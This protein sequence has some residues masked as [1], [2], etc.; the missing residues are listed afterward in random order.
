MPLDGSLTFEEMQARISGAAPEEPDTLTFEEMQARIGAALPP[1]STMEA[2]G[3]NVVEFGKGLVPGA[4]KAAGTTLSG[5]AA[6]GSSRV[7]NEYFDRI[8]RGESVDDLFTSSADPFA[9][10]T[11]GIDHLRAAVGAY[12]RADPA[13]R[14]ELRGAYPKP[15]PVQ[16][17]ATY[18]TGQD[19]QKIGEGLLPAAPGY[20][21][22][23]GRQLGEGVG[24]VI[25]G[26]ATSALTGPL[27][28][29]AAFA[30]MGAGEAVDRAIKNGATEDQIIKSARLGLLPGVTDSIPIETLLGRLPVPG[31]KFITL[32]LNMIGSAIKVAGRIGWQATI[33]GIQEGGQAFLQNLI[34]RE[35][36]KPEQRLAENV[37]PEAGL[38]AGV[39]AI[40]EAGRQLLVGA[41]GRRGRGPAP[42]APTLTPDDRASPLPDDLIEEGKKIIAAATGGGPTEPPGGGAGAVPAPAPP[43]PGTAPTPAPPIPGAA[44]APT[45]PVTPTVEI[46]DGTQGGQEVRGPVEV[47]QE[48]G[49]AVV[50]VGGEQAA[51]AG[52]NVPPN[53]I[54]RNGAAEVAPVV[55]TTGGQAPTAPEVDQVAAEAEPAPLS[56]AQ[57]QLK[58]RVL[59]K[60]A[61]EPAQAMPAPSPPEPA[62]PTGPKPRLRGYKAPLPKRPLNIF[63]FIAQKGGIRDVGGEVRSMDLHRKFIPRFGTLVRPRGLDPDL[64]REAAEDAGYI[65]RGGGEDYQATDM[66]DLWDAMRRQNFGEEVYPAGSEG[67]LEEIENKRF[68]KM[69]KEMR[70]EVEAEA[71][72]EKL[73]LPRGPTTD[74]TDQGP[75]A[76]IPG[77]ERVSEAEAKRAADRAEM[78]RR[79]EAREA[80][81]KLRAK[82]PQAGAGALFGEPEKPKGP[83]Q[84]GLFSLPQTETPEF[85]AWFG[86]SKVVDAEGKPL[87]VFHA[88]T[89]EEQEEIAPEIGSEGFHFGT[90]TASDFR[91]GGKAID[92]FIRNI[93]TSQDDDG[94][95]HWSSEGIDSFDMDETGFDT[96][97]DAREDGE[98][99]AISQESDFSEPMPV[100]EVYLSIKNPKRVRDQKDNWTT[101]V[102]KAKEEGYDG[103]VYRN[104]FEDKGSDSWVV[105]RPEQIKSATGNRGTFD[106]NDP[107]ISYSLSPA[108]REAMPAIMEDLRARLAK[109]GIADKVALKW[110]NAIHSM[111]T[112]GPMSAEGRYSRIYASRELAKAQ[113]RKPGDALPFYR[114]IEV[115]LHAPD[116]AWTLDH[117]IIHALRD[118]VLIRPAEWTAL[119]RA[120]TADKAR[121]A[122]IRRRYKDQ[123]LEMAPAEREDALVEEAVADMFADWA[124]G[125]TEA[126]GFIRT[127]FERIKAFFTALA[128][129][130]G[131]HGFTTVDQ[132]FGRIEAGE[133]GAREA[134]GATTAAERFAAAWHGSP[135]DFDAFSTDKIGTGEGA[136][137]YG[138][139]L[140]FSGRRDVAEYYR[141]ALA[142]NRVVKYLGK[143]VASPDA[144]STVTDR[145]LFNVSYKISEG[146]APQDAIDAAILQYKGAAPTDEE[147]R[148]SSAQRGAADRYEELASAARSLKPADFTIDRGRLYRVDLAPAEDEY[149]LWDKPLSEQSEKVKAGLRKAGLVQET[150]ITDD[151]IAQAPT[152]EGDFLRAQ[153]DSLK[154][155]WLM[156]AENFYNSLA[157]AM[158]PDGALRA[159][160]RAAS[161]ALRDAGI[162]GIKYLDQGSRVPSFRFDASGTTLYGGKAT[163]LTDL[164][165]ADAARNLLGDEF[166][167]AASLTALLIRDG[168]ENVEAAK[169]AASRH[170]LSREQ[171]E[172]LAVFAARITDDA[173]HNYV[174]FDESAVKIEEKFALPRPPRPSDALASPTFANAKIEAEWRDARKGAASQE[175]M[176]TRVR[177]WLTEFGHGWTRHFIHLPNTARFADV[178]QQ[179]RKLEAAPT[180]A[181]E[182]VVRYLK[183]ITDGMTPDDMDGFTRKI[184]LDDLA[185]EVTREHDLPFKMT[186]ESVEADRAALDAWVAQRPDIADAV[187]RRTA[188]V[189]EITR[190]LVA[191]GVFTREQAANPAYYRHQVLDYARGVVAAAQGR[192]TYEATVRGT[193]KRLRTPHWARRMGST[194]NINANFLE[195]E[196]DWMH[197]A[198]VDITT[199]K[200]I[201]W[202]K[203]SDHNVRADVIAQARASNSAL[204][205]REL[206]DEGDGGP[207]RKQW[208]AFRQ[209]IA[210]GLRKV[211]QAIEDGAIDVPEEYQDAADQLVDDA[212]DNEVSIFPFLTWIMDNNEAGAMGAAMTFKA[213][214]QRREWVRELL[215]DRYADPMDVGSLV[216]RFAPEGYVAWQPEEGK[217]LFTAKTLSENA[218]ARMLRRMAASMGDVVPKAEVLAALQ[219]V[220]SMLAMGGNKFELVIPQELAATLNSLRDEQ[221]D[222]LLDELIREP[223]RWWK[224]WTLINPAQVGKY[225]IN[226]LSGDLDAVIAGNPKALKRTGEAIKELWQVMHG[227]EPSARYQEA[228]ERGVFDSGLSIQEIPDINFLSEFEGLIEKGGPVRRFALSPL[229]K[230]WN[231]LQ[232]YTQFRENW[233][234][235]A[236]YLN[237]ADRLEGGESMESIGYGAVKPELLDAVEDLKDK[238]AFL[239]RNLV[240]DYG[241]VSRNGKWIRERLV[242]FWSFQE[243]NLKRYLRLTSNAFGQGVGKGLATGG[244]MGAM[245][246]VRASAY[247]GLR[248]AIL[249]G[250]VQLWNR[251]CGCCDENESPEEQA[252]LHLCLGKIGDLNVTLRFQG[253]LS[254]AMGWFGFAD[255]AGVIS[256]IEKGRGT[257]GD[258]L[259]AVAKAP[260]NKVGGSLTPVIT[261]PLESATGKKLWPDVFN[262]RPIRDRWRN[263]FETF[264]VAGAYDW[265]TGK[266]TR[267]AGTAAAKMLVN[268]SDPDEAAYSRARGLAFDWL[269]RVK[270]QEGFTDS[271]TPRANTLYEWRLAMK[272]GDKEAERRAF[273]R[274]RELGV[275]AA[276]RAASIPRAHPAGAIAK[277]DRLTF[278]RSLSNDERRMYNRAVIWYERTF[279]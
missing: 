252:R 105:F 29:A 84:G 11:A 265:L 206:A 259:G 53:E 269:E 131:I 198:L 59:A 193:T 220:K 107:R 120:A 250:Y 98:R 114:L 197:K 222:N 240:G 262:P 217:L 278:L 144:D 38:G 243:I 128:D 4:V 260:V 81:Q 5:A 163:T 187:A 148:A 42:P 158:R 106:P 14:T 50:E 60:R 123:F 40:T 18:K 277:K 150:T 184:V 56:T 16:E 175:T 140:Y 102:R 178:G 45:S 249:Y 154:Y 267:G 221:V 186:P 7:I 204:V 95:W 216:K 192:P 119:E 115:A 248:I 152:A 64:I 266:P 256:E 190:Q 82:K 224:R 229:R 22:S 54:A 168:Y 151:Q 134:G 122:D 263:L 181:K 147:Q 141:R 12:R 72:G 66:N 78:K 74:I 270:G 239:A 174:I 183:G 227:A 27:G 51:P 241:N 247:L 83:E 88:G 191:E 205:Q 214:S 68:D 142:K 39:G 156:P 61:A 89:F 30:L 125:R 104:E 194:F 207:L 46:P 176:L 162:P 67:W 161:L 201:T 17:T 21:E 87:V 113:G 20:E 182:F 133:V 230:V 127:A 116:K 37:L 97:S 185:Y 2:V 228:Q 231:A 188:A 48:P 1:D 164:G 167:P 274:L 112:G 118:L 19:V 49:Q 253:A 177:L 10:P 58:A 153:R 73:S 126:R 145:A 26:V 79:I 149:L 63:E 24:T 215:G 237:Y 146:L 279:K 189:R 129:A 8:D 171:A 100:T 179:L 33:E 166:H 86:D 80:Q 236:A 103:L 121:M 44:A 85:K 143:I 23:V 75:Q 130:L 28:A 209:Q 69:L 57:D 235:Y 213:I 132:V 225:N 9:A 139:G 13:G 251:L 77:A 93:E 275:D 111:L 208:T 165:V 242:P 276:A 91:Q 36:Y 136:Q 160:P 226:N 138:H 268:L 234:R 52:G 92:S 202:I 200:T 101:A 246:G 155:R 195:A 261:V 110:T 124:A 43:I 233:L 109:V 169:T 223:L 137:A 32:P 254:D 25:A 90:K 108:A 6:M 47:G 117:E 212:S 170:G 3:Q 245:M 71:R 55:P 232:K 135:H 31:G 272:Y 244:A 258:F 62:A 210:I 41:A 219:A 35:V 211:R 157:A 172:Q 273:A 34:A 15:P 94:R 255:A 218:L 199:A 70:P 180:A 173:T 159:D 238:A 264:S 65:G 96:E 203:E 99:T 76:V 196:F 257:L 271:M